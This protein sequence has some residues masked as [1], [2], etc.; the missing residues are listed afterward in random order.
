VPDW[1]YQL[2]WHHLAVPH[3]SQHRARADLLA[4]ASLIFERSD[5]MKMFIVFALLTVFVLPSPSFAGPQQYG[6]ALSEAA[7]TNGS[8]TPHG[9]W[10]SR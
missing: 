4:G 9:V 6:N 8:I 5:I 2:V 1:L 7:A 10:D 3:L